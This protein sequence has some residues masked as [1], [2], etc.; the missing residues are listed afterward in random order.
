MPAATIDLR[1]AS[2]EMPPDQH[3]PVALPSLPDAPHSASEAPRPTSQ[4]PLH[5][6]EVPVHPGDE[7]E[8]ERNIRE[9]N[10][11]IQTTESISRV[12][13]RLRE[14]LLQLSRSA[15][16]VAA[17][18]DE[19][20]AALCSDI[21]MLDTAKRNL[22]KSIAALRQLLMIAAAVEQLREAAL[23]RRYKEAAKLLLALR[24][25]CRSFEVYR[26]IPRVAELLHQ[27][28]LLREGLQ[29]QLLEDFENSVDGEN[30]SNS[31]YW[32]EKLRDAGGC[33]DAVG[34][35][36]FREQVV[37]A[38]SGCLLTSYMATFSPPPA[39]AIAAA[40]ESTPSSA[41]AAET[42]STA[43]ASFFE[44]RFGWYRRAVRDAESRLRDILPLHWRFNEA[45][46]MHFC[47]VTKQQLADLLEIG[48]HYLRPQQLLTLIR[49]AKVFEDHAALKQDEREDAE[50]DGST[51]DPVVSAAAAEEVIRLPPPVSFA[52]AISS[53][54]EGYMGVWLAAEEEKLCNKLSLALQREKILRNASVSALACTTCRNSSSKNPFDAELSLEAAGESGAASAAA[55]EEGE[56]C[57]YSSASQVF[58]AC[59]GLMELTLS[60][61]NKQTMADVV[62]AFKRLFVRYINVLETRLP[63]SKAFL[64]G[65]LAAAVATGC[66]PSL[67]AEDQEGEADVEDQEAQELIVV[68]AVLGSC[69]YFTRTLQRMAAAIEAQ[70]EDSFKARCSFHEQN[71]L[72]FALE[73]R[74]IRLLL[75]LFGPSL[76][77]LVSFLSKTNFTSIAAVSAASD[78]VL[79]FCAS[80]KYGMRRI[81]EFLSSPIFRFVA[82]KLAQQVL[83][84]YREGLVSCKRECSVR[85]SAEEIDKWQA[86]RPRGKSKTVNVTSTA[87][88]ARQ[89]RSTDTS[90][91]A[92]LST[93]DESSRGAVV[94]AAALEGLEPPSAPPV[95]VETNPFAPSPSNRGNPF[96]PGDRSGV[97][98]LTL[99]MAA[100]KLT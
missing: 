89:L 98:S 93:A 79:A 94:A 83:A 53:G 52:G 57:L 37:A 84:Q 87:A 34:V 20:A 44:R 95:P 18:S 30:S 69:S 42:A 1:S 26:H 80:L 2:S 9:L 74:C 56:V 76:T 5:P 100:Q 3:T 28:Q 67:R 40:D 47:R 88:A 92:P 85:I 60:F 72:L 97:S 71:E 16:Q 61:S 43:A 77:S 8:D 51:L 99:R 65:P 23:Y 35:K 31:G 82:D 96:Q 64:T 21:K 49:E 91:S 12:D 33:V 19:E 13:A 27:Q 66:F 39:P 36:G 50:A 14:E 75:D 32:R 86:L 73:G 10:Q 55:G 38:V 24:P 54:F 78:P 45:F 62:S 17:A 68:A 48:Q 59:K 70:I 7:S 11:Q 6:L 58:S 63:P 81:A 15:Q 90:A 46:A 22:T 41:A 29:Q 4:L 25:L